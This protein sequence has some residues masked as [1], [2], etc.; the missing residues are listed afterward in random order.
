MIQDIYEY[1]DIYS[2][3]NDEPLIYIKDLNIT[4]KDIKIMGK[5]QDTIKIEKFGIAYMKFHAKE[6]LEE[7]AQFEEIKINLVGRGNI[8]TWMGNNTPQIFIEAY[9]LENGRLSF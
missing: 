2:Q 5:N 3:Q 7:L 6:F 1:R 9:E 4:R 8:N